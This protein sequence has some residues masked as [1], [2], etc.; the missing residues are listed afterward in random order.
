MRKLQQEAQWHEFQ[1]QNTPRPPHTSTFGGAPS[2]IYPE[3]QNKIGNL[4]VSAFTTKV[5]LQD[6]RQQLGKRG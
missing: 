3:T 4:P 1:L 5:N 6:K 2:N